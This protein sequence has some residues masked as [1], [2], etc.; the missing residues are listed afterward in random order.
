MTSQTVFVFT[1]WDA[2]FAALYA[3]AALWILALISLDV[4][5]DVRRWWRRRRRS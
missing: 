2:T 1:P 4:I 5:R 3:W